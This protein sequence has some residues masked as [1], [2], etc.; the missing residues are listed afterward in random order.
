MGPAEV[1]T[2]QVAVEM[3]QVRGSG[4]EHLRGMCRWLEGVG[5]RESALCLEFLTSSRPGA[6]ALMLGIQVE[7]AV[8]L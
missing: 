3:V 4:R 1:D 8:S 5:Q 6:Q 7:G 2:L